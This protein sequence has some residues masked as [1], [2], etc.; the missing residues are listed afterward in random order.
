M[1]HPIG[2]TDTK[3]VD[4]LLIVGAAV[5]MLGAS[6]WPWSGDI[7]GAGVRV[8]SALAAGC[9]LGGGFAVGRGTRRAFTLLWAALGASLA[10]GVIGI[11]SI[12]LIY[13]VAS[14]L[15]ILAIG[16]SPNHSELSSRFDRR[17]VWIAAIAFIVI[18]STAIIYSVGF[19][20][21]LSDAVPQ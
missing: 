10:L 1:I 13:I 4:R 5:L 15:I 20:A 17:Y 16:T 18:F 11:F 7:P 19:R 9:L 14:L 8:L 2:G 21:G 3:V 12:G 6:W